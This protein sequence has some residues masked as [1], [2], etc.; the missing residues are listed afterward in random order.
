MKQ[1]KLK[2]I[3]DNYGWVLAIITGL[4][5][6]FT[7]CLKFLN[8]LYSKIEFG[9]YGLDYGMYVVED[10]GIIFNFCFSILF[11]LCFYSLCYCYY[12]I[13]KM[14]KNKKYEVKL[15]LENIILILLS[16]GYIIFSSGIKISWLSVLLELFILLILEFI[17][18]IIMC[19]IIT[20]EVKKVDNIN[21]FF[22]YIKK[23]PFVVLFLILLFIFSHTFSLVNNKEFR[24]INDNKVI[25]YTT[26]DYYLL[27]DCEITEKEIKIYKGT[28]TKIDNINVESKLIDFKK[29]NIV[30][31]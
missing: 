24:I 14:I 3:Q 27:L 26:N 16:N 31:N 11:A 7:F 1:D 29:V 15:L 10:I 5:V 17:M 2:L 25:V 12:Q 20:K 6:F 18:T 28:Q 13:F 19:K 21:D 9:Y 22:N 8:Y 4:G 23:L 30:D